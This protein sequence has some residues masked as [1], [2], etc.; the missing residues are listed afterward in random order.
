MPPPRQQQQ[1]LAFSAVA[2]SSYDDLLLRSTSTPVTRPQHAAPRHVQFAVQNVPSSPSLRQSHHP[3]HAERGLEVIRSATRTTAVT[4]TTNGSHRSSQPRTES[5]ESQATAPK[6]LQKPHSARKM[7]TTTMKKPVWDADVR[8]TPPL[9]DATIK[10]ATLFQ[11]RSGDRRQELEK[12][13]RDLR[14]RPNQQ[15]QQHRT[16]SSAM[17]AGAAHTHRQRK[18]ILRSSA[19]QASYRNAKSAVPTARPTQLPPR[20]PKDFIRLNFE[21]IAGRSFAQHSKQHRRSAS[22]FSRSNVFDRLSK[23]SMSASLLRAVRFSSTTDLEQSEAPVASVT[24]QDAR[25]V[26]LLHSQATHSRVTTFPHDNS[27]QDAVVSPISSRR[28][29]D[30]ET[31]PQL[32][33]RVDSPAMRPSPNQERSP[34]LSPKA[35]RSP[36]SRSPRNS[37]SQTQPNYS[38]NVFAVLDRQQR[39]RIGVNQILDGLRLLGL[40]ATHNQVSHSNASGLLST[41]APSYLC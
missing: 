34:R 1:Q 29:I 17:T 27:V 38:A 37:R 36:L 15:Q 3:P 24:A 10:K 40:P 26:R 8:H 21:Q 33:I 22:A 35:S 6:H 41:T 32:S 12:E 31:S 5:A 39:G 19:A 4:T 16:S 2:T 13:A 18:K 9:F 20:P 14:D 30:A 23:P 11:P 7:K 25:H 28:L